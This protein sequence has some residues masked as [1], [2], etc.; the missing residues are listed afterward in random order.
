MA[1]FTGAIM[2]EPEPAES[3]TPSPVVCPMC[4]L[5]PGETGVVQETL[6]QEEHADLLASYGF[7]PGSPVTRVGSAPQGDPLIFRL[8]GRLVA[9]R[10][11]TAAV[12]MVTRENK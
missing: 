5:S 12:I 10:R 4:D 6:W 3:P 9:V 11:E 1:W 8:E 7:F 2:Q